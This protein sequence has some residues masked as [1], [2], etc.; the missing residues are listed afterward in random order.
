MVVSCL[1]A[2][3]QAA[4]AL[5]YR[6]QDHEEIHG[7]NIFLF[8]EIFLLEKPIFILLSCRWTTSILIQAGNVFIHDFTQMHFCIK[9]ITGSA[10]NPII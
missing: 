8:F 7:K 6:K 1:L 9:Y 4:P 2:A 10:R 3:V 5:P